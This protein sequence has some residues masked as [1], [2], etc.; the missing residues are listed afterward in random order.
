MPRATTM[1]ST[2]LTALLACLALVGAGVQAQNASEPA[3]KT[4]RY[5]FLIA[6]S[7]FD[8]PQ[9]TDLYSRTIAASIFEA[10]LEYE[11]LARPAR[12]RPNTAAAMPEISADFRSFTFRIKPGIH[13]AD[14]PVFKG[15]KRELVAED[16]VYSIKRHYDPR[17][18]S[19]NLYTFENAKI[20]GMAE[21]RKN[22]LLYTSRC[23]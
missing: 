10:P 21:L 6:E 1:K 4:L 20:L 17:W 5:A 12:M 11:F 9:I 8:P 15:R 22:C 2:L 7:T 14:D 19:G 3:A 18:K 16:Y 23:V 13:F